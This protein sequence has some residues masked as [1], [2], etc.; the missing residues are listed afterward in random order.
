[1]CFWFTTRHTVSPSR[2][3]QWLIHALVTHYIN[4]FGPIPTAVWLPHNT[5][6]HPP[7]HLLRLPRPAVLFPHLQPPPSDSATIPSIKQVQPGESHRKK[8]LWQDTLFSN[9]LP[10]NNT[11]TVAAWKYCQS[12]HSSTVPRRRWSIC[13]IAYSFCIG[14]KSNIFPLLVTVHDPIKSFNDKIYHLQE[15]KF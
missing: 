7:L 13:P 4:W 5:H 3:I 11:F 10:G 15:F 9:Y 14:A 12:K 2:R 1:V 8:P 6:R